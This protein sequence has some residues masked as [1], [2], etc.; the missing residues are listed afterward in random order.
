MDTEKI[1]QT[2][3]L[4]VAI[5]IVVIILTVVGII[6]MKYEVEGDK[7]MPFNLSK[8]VI[9]STAEGVETKGDSKWNFN[10]YQNNDLY[11]YI[12]KN[13]HYQGNDTYIEKVRIE[14]VQMIQTPKV[15]EIKAYMP[16]STEGRIYS[17]DKAYII[18]EKLEYKGGAKSNPQ[19]LEIGSQGGSMLVRF[20]NTNMGTY[21]SDEDKEI[22]HDGTLLNKLKLTKEDIAFK[23][24]FDFVIQIKNHDYRANIQMDLPSGDILEKGTESI[25]KNDMSDIIFKRDK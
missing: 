7:N 3:K 5:A 17:Y 18:G 16:N 9:V 4:C 1:K 20:S 22:I 12:D 10:I 23:V 2:I 14:N 21:S 24:S 19:V 15:G 25:E 8:I 11:F 6:M 13:T